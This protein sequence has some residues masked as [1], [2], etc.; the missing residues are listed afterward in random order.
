MIFASWGPLGRPL[1]GLLGR[2]GG[3]LGRLGAILG[4]LERS[5]GVLGPSGGTVASPRVPLEALL[6]RLGALLGPK[7]S[8]DKLRGAPEGLR[9]AQEKSGRGAPNPLMIPQE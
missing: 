2:L 4:V 3:L 1:G 9:Q 6:A 5:L 7:K 8:R